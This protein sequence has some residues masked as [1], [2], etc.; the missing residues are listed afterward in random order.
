M[1]LVIRQEKLYF[2]NTL[3][4]D[5][6]C[7]FP[8]LLICF[9]LKQFLICVENIVHRILSMISLYSIVENSN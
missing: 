8:F 9:F 4:T 7:F 1:M 6:K 3:V 5:A 2:L